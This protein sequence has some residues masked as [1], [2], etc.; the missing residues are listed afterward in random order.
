MNQLNYSLF[1]MNEATVNPIASS[2]KLLYFF[3]FER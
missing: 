2:E 1:K 3:K